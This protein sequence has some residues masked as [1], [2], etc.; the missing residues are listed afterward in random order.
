MSCWS[1]ENRV[2][3]G[4]VLCQG[5]ASPAGRSGARFGSAGWSS[6]ADSA[7]RTETGRKWADCRTRR[8]L[9]TAGPGCKYLRW[10]E[11]RKLTLIS[12]PK[13]Q[14][15]INA[16]SMWNGPYADG[17]AMCSSMKQPKP[18]RFVEI[19]GIPMTVHS[20]GGEKT[21]KVG[22]C[23]IIVWWIIIIICYYRI[24]SRLC[25]SLTW[26]VTPRLIVRGEDAQVATSHK[27][28]IIHGK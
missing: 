13:K 12:P 25:L 22:G 19:D 11:R 27:V 14:Q 26:C 10:W 3:F 23:W 17:S 20:A 4:S 1:Q 28:L 5:I 6:G 24:I 18:D 15:L 21:K 2:G 9:E 16:S 8:P 7:Y